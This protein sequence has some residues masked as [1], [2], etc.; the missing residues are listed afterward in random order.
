MGQIKT[1]P[2]FIGSDDG[3]ELNCWQGI[4]W[5]NGDLIH[6]RIYAPLGLHELHNICYENTCQITYCWINIICNVA[7]NLVREQM[8]LATFGRSIFCYLFM[9]SYKIYCTSL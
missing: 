1:K 4:I 3:L 5:T 6:L 9:T 8:S 7:A 2:S